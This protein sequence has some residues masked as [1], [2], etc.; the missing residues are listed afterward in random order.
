MV[1][2]AEVLAVFVIFAPAY[3]GRLSA[4]ARSTDDHH[5]HQPYR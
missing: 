4:P 1:T 2:D 3:T 5:N